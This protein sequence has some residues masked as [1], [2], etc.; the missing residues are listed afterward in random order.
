M[1]E[2]YR[3]QVALLVKVLPQVAE[4]H[5]LALHGGT[6]INLFVRDMPRLSVDLDLTYRP[7]EDRRTSL[8]RIER[9]LSCIGER[10]ER[11]IPDAGVEHVRDEAKLYVSRRGARM[12]L[13]VNLV[14]RGTLEE[15]VRM[16]LCER[17]REEFAG[18][19]EMPLVPLGQLYGG[20]VC[21][22]LDRQHPRD[23]F[24]AR[25]LM[26]NEGFRDDVRRGFVFCLLSSNRPLH[27]LLSPGMPDRR[28]AM[29]NRF[30][31]M[32]DVEFT[33]EDFEATRQA[34]VR[35][36]NQGL[37]PEDREFLLGVNRCEPDWRI[38]D[39]ERFPS[40]QWKLENLR[41]LKERDS[42]KHEGQ[43]DALREVLE[44]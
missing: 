15:P 11:E 37:S 18:F 14:M 30:A 41:R 27:E 8:E 40:V 20:K 32:S 23:M 10:I 31:G 6:A 33:Y 4:E 44:A 16:R 9:A 21:A 39:F 1:R 29:G 2:A 22:A 25:L 38:H 43:C 28:E 5:C 34:L 19:A 24:D 3:S 17:A 36:V 26:A 35:M 12:K 7:L 42:V 13:E